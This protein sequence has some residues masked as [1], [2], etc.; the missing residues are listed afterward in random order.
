VERSLE[1]NFS[2]FKTLIF[3]HPNLRLGLFIFGLENAHL[4]RLFTIIS[5]HDGSFA[6]QVRAGLPDDVTDQ[7]DG[8]VRAVP[9]ASAE[10]RGE[11]SLKC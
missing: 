5:F 9:H 6:L 1:L 8:V 7:E 10:E 11:G 3:I 4:D 2:F